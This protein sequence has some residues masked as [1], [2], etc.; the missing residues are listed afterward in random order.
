MKKLAIGCGIVVLLFAVAG[1][2]VTYYVYRQV[3]SAVAQFAEFAQVPELEKSVRNRSAFTPPSTG[4]I[5]EQQIE[6][7]VRV[8]TSIRQRLGERFAELEQRHKALLAKGEAAAVDL[9][10]LLSLYRG[11]AATWMDGKRQQIEAL[12]EAGFSL[13]E[14]RWVRD[15][16]YTAIG[17][18]FMEIDVSRIVQDVQQGVTSM[19]TSMLRGAL[20]T[21]GTDP[22]ASLVERFKKQLED[23]LPLAVLGL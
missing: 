9:P 10:E 13:E 20:G 16:A 6:R 7:L 14:Y 4:Q 17:L 3:S 2:A 19:D 21:D 1:A 8:Q 5:T 12:N 22:N 15:R 11:L 23:N 18:P